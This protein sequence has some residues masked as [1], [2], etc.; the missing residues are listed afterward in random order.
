MMAGKGKPA[1]ETVMGAETMPMAVRM[2]K[3]AGR[4]LVKNPAG[5]RPHIAENEF[6]N[7]LPWQGMIRAND[8]TMEEFSCPGEPRV[9]NAASVQEEQ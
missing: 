9:D 7:G 2:L 8:D 5:D 6:F 4:F 3:K 1:H